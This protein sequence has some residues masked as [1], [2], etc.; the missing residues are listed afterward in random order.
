MTDLA[1]AFVAL[2][3]DL[4]T[5][6]ANDRAILA[7]ISQLAD[8]AKINESR[9]RVGLS[10]LAAPSLL[11]TLDDYEQ[12]GHISEKAFAAACEYLQGLDAE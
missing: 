2:A 9:E 10:A 3:A 5:P 12:N 6:G 1:L 7:V 11:R 8:V 4:Q